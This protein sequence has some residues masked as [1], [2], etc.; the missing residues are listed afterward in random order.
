MKLEEVFNFYFNGKES[1]EQ[2]YTLSLNDHIKEF[3]FNNKKCY[4][5]SDELK[6]IQLFLSKF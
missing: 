1:F 5:I 6:T 2:F 3:N 4:S